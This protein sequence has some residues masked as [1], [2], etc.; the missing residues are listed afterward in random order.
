MAKLESLALA[1]AQSAEANPI[2]I[3]AVS[4]GLFVLFCCRSQRMHA[5]F[6][7]KKEK[8]ANDGTEC[9]PN[10]STSAYSQLFLRKKIH[11]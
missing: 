1:G 5:F 2:I 11:H 3:E 6:S 8:L 4:V 10:F 9:L 7:E